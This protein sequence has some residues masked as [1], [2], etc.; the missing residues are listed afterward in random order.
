MTL[1]YIDWTIVGVVLIAVTLIAIIS[2]CYTKSVADFLS[3]NRSGGRYLLAVAEGFAVMGAIGFVGVWEMYYE[4]GFTPEWW[5]SMMIPGGIII[6]VTGYIIYRYRETKAMTLAE[7]FE[8]RYSKKFRI[9][10]G[11]LCFTSGILNFGIFPGIGARFFIYFA[12]LPETLSF[13]SFCISTFPTVMAFLLLLSVFYVWMGGQVGV[14]ITDFFSGLFSNI[15]YLV[16]VVVA[17]FMINWSQIGDALA[18]APQGQSMINPFDGGEIKNFSVWYFL[19]ATIGAFYSFMSWQGAQG[20]NC[21]AKSPHEAKMARIV[22]IWRFHPQTLVMLMVPIIVYTI[23]HLIDFSSIASSANEVLDQIS[24][25]TIKSQMTVP[26]VISKFLP[27][28]IKGALFALML[29]AFIGNI[30]TYLHSWGSIFIQD[31]VM[32]F[33]KT[34]FTQNQHLWLLRLSTCGVAVFVF[35]FSLL[36]EPTEAILMFFALTGAIF[37]GG[38]GAVI[39]GGLYWKMGTTRGAWAA[40][41]IGSCLAFAT[42]ILRYIWPATYGTDFPINSQWIYGITMFCS[43]SFYIIFSLLENRVFNLEKML[44]RGIYA[45]KQSPEEQKQSDD[46]N[47]SQNTIIGLIFRRLGLS[48]EFTR[49]DR[50]IFY[51]TITWSL[52]WLVVFLIGTGCYFLNVIPSDFWMKFW[53]IKV[54]IVFILGLV[55]TIWIGIGGLKDLKFMLKSLRTTRRDEKDDGMIRNETVGDENVVNNDIVVN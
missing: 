36:Y 18:T 3:A 5:S 27:V 26:V 33:R 53:K 42:F 23:M 46:F 37:I 41:I 11:I 52:T 34:S 35:F 2:K 19:I 45:L 8:M 20:F 15:I 54:M 17:A 9:F 4:A 55:S 28:G 31:V 39:I 24:S 50:I 22:G 7:F 38:S 40:M 32:P 13:G 43:A 12:G 48:K 6:T 47:N 44:H 29:A 16:I 51:A 14:I 1:N 10:A 49:W 21:S 25:K 30:D